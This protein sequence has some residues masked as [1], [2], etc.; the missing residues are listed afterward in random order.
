MLVT[1]YEAIQR[2]K[3]KISYTEDLISKNQN[4]R[5]KFWQEQDLAAFLIA[6]ASIEYAQQMADYE[7][8]QSTV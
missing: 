8:A 7:A 1:N 2:I 5:Q 4:A 3:Q 6:V